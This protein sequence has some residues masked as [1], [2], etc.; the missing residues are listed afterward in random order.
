MKLAPIDM[1]KEVEKRFGD[2][3]KGGWTK[4]KIAN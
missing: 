2:F 1:E 4:F 3:K